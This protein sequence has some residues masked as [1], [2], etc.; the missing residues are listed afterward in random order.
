MNV[1][2]VPQYDASGFDTGLWLLYA[3]DTIY[4]NLTIYLSGPSLVVGQFTDWDN[5]SYD[6]YGYI[7][8]DHV[9]LGDLV[10]PNPYQN[11]D[12]ATKLYEWLKNSDA[13]SV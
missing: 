11:E 9:L 10:C 12:A 2:V 5:E 13:V 3:E 4:E 6:E 7:D 1:E 8:A